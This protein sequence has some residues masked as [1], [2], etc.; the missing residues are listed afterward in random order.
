MAA[1]SNPPAKALTPPPAP[2]SPAAA[3]ASSVTL[4]VALHD[5]ATMLTR[6]SGL[7]PGTI[8][9]QAAH[10]QRKLGALAHTL[11]NTPGF[12]TQ[13][14]DVLTGYANAASRLKETP[15]PA[16]KLIADEL[17][18]LDARW[19][20]ILMALGKAQHVNLLAGLPPLLLPQS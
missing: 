3:A 4:V 11:P 9:T 5:A 2:G 8:T 17:V 18:S 20:A 13:L 14:H 16:A 6:R 12:G 7:P 19:K 1:S 15:T 10:L